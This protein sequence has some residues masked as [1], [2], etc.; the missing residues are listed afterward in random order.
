MLANL[1]RDT[2]L[3]STRIILP[4]FVPARNDIRS[5]SSQPSIP[6][7]SRYGRSRSDSAY[8]NS[9]PITKSPFALTLYT[10]G[11]HL[12]VVKDVAF[13]TF[14][15]LFFPSFSRRNLSF[16]SLFCK[17]LSTYRTKFHGGKALYSFLS[18]A[19]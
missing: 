19:Q 17:L 16:R 12:H 9:D 8:S 6:R 4:F 1:T 13:F 10:R 2:H 11:R 3:R 18:H 5:P 14:P 15:P 7:L